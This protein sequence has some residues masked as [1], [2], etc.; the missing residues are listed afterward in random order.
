MTTTN[1]QIIYFKVT[2]VWR[3]LC[4]LHT[5]LLDK[6]FEEYSLLLKSEIDLIDDLIKEKQVIIKQITLIDDERMNIINELNTIL[7]AEGKSEIESVSHLIKT[8]EAFEKENET[9]H[10]FRFNSLLIDLIEKLQEQNKRNQVF[11][12]KAINNLKDIREEAI[13]VKSYQTYNQKGFSV[14]Q[15][16]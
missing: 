13:G 9:R 12:N 14:K 1:L 3:R 10:L 8:M 5:D 7:K 16:T 11:L 6:T 4:E 15:A 2:D